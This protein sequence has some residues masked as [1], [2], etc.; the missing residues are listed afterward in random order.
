MM[1]D[2]E[3]E[4]TVICLFMYLFLFTFWPCHEVCG[5]LVLPPG[6]APVLPAGEAG[7][8]TAGLP[9]R[10]QEKDYLGRVSSLLR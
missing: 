3:S 4:R 10:S 7:V 8:L 1:E 9:G 2:G 5:I 6:M